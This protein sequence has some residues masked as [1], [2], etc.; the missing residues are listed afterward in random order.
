MTEKE[1][2]Y[3]SDLTYCY[4][5]L[6]SKNR[7]L[8]LSPITALDIKLMLINVYKDELKRTDFKIIES[9]NKL[10]FVNLLNGQEN[11]FD[12]TE[13]NLGKIHFRYKNGFCESFEVKD[14]KPLND[15]QQY[16]V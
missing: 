3:K 15:L 4:K 10:I 14:L 7:V 2:L 12:L 9:D 13:L 8:V 5:I 16:L 11:V 6:K 1:I